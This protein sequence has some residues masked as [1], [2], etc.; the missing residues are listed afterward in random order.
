MIWGLCCIFG[1]P[2]M[3]IYPFILS[4]LVRG[5]LSLLFPCTLFLASSNLSWALFWFLLYYINKTSTWA[6]ILAFY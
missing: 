6:S 2:F 1:L 3:V 5:G 4:K